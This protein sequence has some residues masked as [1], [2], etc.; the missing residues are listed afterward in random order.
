MQKALTY[1]AILEMD[2]AITHDK[3]VVVSHDAVLNAK[4][5]LA[6]NGQPLGNEKIR[7]YQTDY[8]DLRK[9]DVGKTS[10]KDFPE[11]ERFPAQIPLFSELVD[12][13]ETFAVSHH[14]VRPVYFVETK[15]TPK[16]DDQN[17]PGP[18]EF[19]DLMM[20]VVKEKGIENR[21]IVQSFDFRTL[22][23]LKKDYPQ[24]KL[25]LLAKDSTSLDENLKVLGFTP[26]YYSINAPFINQELVN[27]CRELKMKLILGNCDDYQ[28]IL[29]LAKMGVDGV[30]TDFPM[31]WFARQNKKSQVSTR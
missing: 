25:A 4:I 31:Q 9:Y 11:Q 21:L 5:T 17:H 2:L 14:L 7:I 26:D 24:R 10:N 19:V 8:A 22:Q 1:G 18:K 12:S 6:P 28:E 3:Q 30:I 16:T 15:I 13:V 27:R 23:V 29:R 20:Q